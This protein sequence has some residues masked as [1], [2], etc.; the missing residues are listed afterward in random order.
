MSIVKTRE[1]R[2]G[3]HKLFKKKYIWLVR[4]K[5]MSVANRSDRSDCNYK[6]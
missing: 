4:P 2:N 5:W 3:N 6:S 1:K